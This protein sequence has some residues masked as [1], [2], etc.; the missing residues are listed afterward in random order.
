M[1]Y[2]SLGLLRSNLNFLYVHDAGIG[3]TG[4]TNF[5][6]QTSGSSSITAAIELLWIAI[7]AVK[8]CFLAQFKFHKPPYAYVSLHLTRY[9]WSCIGICTAAFLFTV[10]QPIILCPNNGKCLYFQQSDTIA[11]EIAVTAVDI[12]TDLLVISIP[13]LLIHMAHF[14]RSYTI[15]NASFKSLSIFTIAIA[16]TR[17]AIQIN[18]SHQRINYLP[19]TFW[20]SVEASLAIIMASISSYRV[21]ILDCLQART[22]NQRDGSARM[23]S[24]KLWFATTPLRQSDTAWSNPVTSDQVSSLSELP[25]VNTGNRNPLV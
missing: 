1:L 12:L 17:L 13:L 14:T 25:M 15:I 22:A 10:A 4:H 5:A 9:Y 24:H 19:M 3:V 2:V 21:P 18:A 7:Y 11:W 8:F 23:R 20:L 6:G 16:A